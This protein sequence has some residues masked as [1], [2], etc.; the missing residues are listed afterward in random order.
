MNY[1]T[2]SLSKDLPLRYF[3]AKKANADLLQQIAEILL[4]KLSHRYIAISIFNT[5]ENKALL[6]KTNEQMIRFIENLSNEKLKKCQLIQE[7]LL[8]GTYNI[9]LLAEIILERRN[10]EFYSQSSQSSLT[11]TSDSQGE[12]EE[13]ES[14]YEDADYSPFEVAQTSLS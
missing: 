11:T 10:K 7:E 8:D 5:V 1:L 14:Q 4:E 2:S 6:P 3:D 13:D 12:S 9:A